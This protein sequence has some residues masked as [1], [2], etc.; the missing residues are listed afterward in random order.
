MAL[1]SPTRSLSQP[2]HTQTPKQSPPSKQASFDLPTNPNQPPVLSR[3]SLTGRR[4]FRTPPS[5]PI[6]LPPVYVVAMN[7]PGR[8][9]VLPIRERETLHTLQ[10]PSVNTTTIQRGLKRKRMKGRRRIHA[11]ICSSSSRKRKVVARLE[12]ARSRERNV[13]TGV[14]VRGS[15]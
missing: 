9:W 6:S 8:W 10:P 1:N 7:Q 3:E 4:E 15:G 11:Y 5:F 14:R 13:Y 2:N 12:C